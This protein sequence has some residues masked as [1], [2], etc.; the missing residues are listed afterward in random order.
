M[1]FGAFTARQNRHATQ[2]RRHLA[3]CVFASEAP[4]PQ[5]CRRTSAEAPSF[6]ERQCSCRRSKPR[7]TLFEFEPWLILFPSRFP[8]RELVNFYH[9]LPLMFHGLVGEELEVFAEQL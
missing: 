2:A 9:D 3:L 6:R 8:S 5:V 4:S 7:S 1:I